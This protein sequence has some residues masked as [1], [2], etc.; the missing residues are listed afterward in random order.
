[1]GSVSKKI[2]DWTELEWSMKAQISHHKN[3]QA[4]K[5]PYI[6]DTAR[7]GNRS[8][9]LEVEQLKRQTNPENESS[10]VVIF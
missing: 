8:M 7:N 4:K 6:E 5:I 2:R 1:M 3:V 10:D 9:L